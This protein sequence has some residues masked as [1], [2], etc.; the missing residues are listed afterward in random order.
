MLFAC[1]KLGVTVMCGLI[2]YQKYNNSR[3]NIWWQWY[4]KKSNEIWKFLF[5]KELHFVIPLKF[6]K[7]I[8]HSSFGADNNLSN[9]NMFEKL[10]I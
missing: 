4:V 9:G 7:A 6:C 8:A 10:Y 1:I 2:N 3:E 5:K